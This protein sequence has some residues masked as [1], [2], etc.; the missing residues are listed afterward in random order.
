[1]IRLGPPDS[2]RTAT[3]LHIP[4]STNRPDELDAACRQV[5]SLFLNELLT[6]MSRAG[7][8]EGMLSGGTGGQVFMAQRN[9]ALAD[10]MGRRGDLGLARMLYEELSQASP[11]NIAD[12]SGGQRQEAQG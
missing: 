1:V 11:Q 12:Q 3:P 6:V 7:F 10:E 2:V 9:A 8:G 5:E 4:A